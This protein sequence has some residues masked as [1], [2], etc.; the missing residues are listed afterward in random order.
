LVNSPGADDAAG[1]AGDG[2]ADGVEKTGALCAGA[3]GADGLVSE[4][5]I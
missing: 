5:K 1:G 3:A 2:G 4:L